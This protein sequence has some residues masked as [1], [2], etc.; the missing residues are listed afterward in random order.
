MLVVQEVSYSL[1]WIKLGEQEVISLKVF[2]LIVEVAY[3]DCVSLVVVRVFRPYFAVVSV[4]WNRFT[5]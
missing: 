5:T 3:H 2:D 4:H 1:D